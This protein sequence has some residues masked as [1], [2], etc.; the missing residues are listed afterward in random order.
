MNTNQ[1]IDEAV[2][3]P[4]E[5]RALVLESLLKS[6][7]QTESNIDDKWI[8]VANKRLSEIRSGKIKAIAGDEVFKK[9]WNRL[10]ED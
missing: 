7:N 3:L 4:V 8:V 2:C 6:F 9:I 10:K 5:Q 1:I